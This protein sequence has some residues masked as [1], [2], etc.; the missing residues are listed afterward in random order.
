MRA[1]LAKWW[2]QWAAS[3]HDRLH[4]E[5]D[6]PWDGYV[7]TANFTVPASAFEDD[8]TTVTYTGDTNG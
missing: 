8:G 6:A 4:V 2:W 1:L 3:V 7:G 5:R